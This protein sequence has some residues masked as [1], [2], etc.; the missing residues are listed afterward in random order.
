MKTMTVKDNFLWMAQ[1]ECDVG[2]IPVIITL[3]HPL[4]ITFVDDDY[5]D[6]TI[7]RPT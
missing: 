4:F 1:Q 2:R 3:V 5:N 7:V 6:I